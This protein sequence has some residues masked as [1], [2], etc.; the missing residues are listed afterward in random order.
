MKIVKLDFYFSYN[1]VNNSDAVI[2]TISIN[3]NN[4]MLNKPAFP[5]FL[6][7]AF[8]NFPHVSGWGRGNKRLTR[9]S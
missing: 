4:S 6:S 9:I 7:L 1:F 5:V 2:C 3:F 8:Y